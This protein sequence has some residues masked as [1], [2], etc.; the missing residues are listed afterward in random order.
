MELLLI[1][2]AAV[3]I[4]SYVFLRQPKSLDI[5]KDGKINTEDVKET[6]K[7]ATQRVKKTLDV[8]KDGRVYRDDLDAA[9]AHTKTA[10]KRT[11]SRVKKSLDINQDGTV[12][13]DDAKTAA[14]KITRR[15][16]ASKKRSVKL[17]DA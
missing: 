15:K 9:L 1:G 4:L 2:I 5:N 6:V 11:A 13:I 16:P 3:G 7:R 17:S 14:K 8:N 10:A 12:N